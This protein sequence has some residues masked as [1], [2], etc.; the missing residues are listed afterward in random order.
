MH[1]RSKLRFTYS[2][3][4]MGY[5][6]LRDWEGGSDTAAIPCNRVDAASGPARSSVA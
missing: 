2:V 5:Q 4:L 6:H 1:T 3:A